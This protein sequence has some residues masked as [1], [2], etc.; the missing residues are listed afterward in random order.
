MIARTPLYL[1]DTNIVSELVRRR[2]DPGVLN[3]FQKQ[4][5]ISISSVVLE[6][7]GY[8]IERAPAEKKAILE[9]WMATF[10]DI[11]PD[12]VPVDRKIALLAGR[13]RGA[14]ESRGRTL[15]QADGLIAATAVQAGMILV[16]RNTR[17]FEGLGL[18]LF[19]P[20]D[21]IL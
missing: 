19:N 8:G 1:L 21:P 17:D 2:P 12:I 5:I 15:S 18:G 20:F 6:E 9:Q 11:P 4:N 7:L 10:L 13:L 14:A 3:W 16:T